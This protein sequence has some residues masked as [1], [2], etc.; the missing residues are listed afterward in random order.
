VAQGPK[1]PHFGPSTY[2]VGDIH[3]CLKPLQ[4]LL[5]KID[6]E[7]D[8]EVV[9]IGDYIDRGRTPGKSWTTF[10]PCLSAA[11]SSWESRAHAPR[12][13]GGAE[14]GT[15]PAER[16]VGHHA[17]LRRDSDN[18]PAAH[19][20]FFQK[21]LPTYETPDYLFVHAGIRPLVPLEQQELKDLIWIRQ[22]FYQFVGKFPKPVVFGH[23]P[24]S[25]SCW[26][27]TE[28]ASTPAA[29]TAASSPASSSP[30]AKS[31]R[32]PAGGRSR[33]LKPAHPPHPEGVRRVPAA[34][35]HSGYPA[36]GWVLAAPFDGLRV[37]G[38]RNAWTHL[39]SVP[40]PVLADG[41]PA[42]RLA[43]GPL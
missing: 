4:R 27:T 33:P 16:R 42:F 26:P 19:L 2:V 29:S 8:E 5:E 23:T 34:L 36:A 13:P 24:S 37:S 11:S 9:F 20:A 17:E 40:A 1:I 7:P 28:S 25:R 31:S 18:I 39:R 12:F 32:F 35:E 43:S 14:R 22:E 6:P 30:S 41:Y 21:L 38:S 3:A 10:S 15:V